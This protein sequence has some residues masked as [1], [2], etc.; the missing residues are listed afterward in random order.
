[1]TR[2]GTRS[3]LR[4]LFMPN[5]HQKRRDAIFLLERKLT[6]C[7]VWF[8]WLESHVRRLITASRH[9]MGP[10]QMTWESHDKAVVRMRFQPRG[11]SGKIRSTHSQF[12]RVD[13]NRKMPVWIRHYSMI[14]RGCWMIAHHSDMASAALER[15]MRC[16]SS[17]SA[18]AR[19]TQQQR[20]KWIV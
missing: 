12:T 16:K 13:E 1:M 6:N 9:S 17:L 20:A 7:K 19:P 10:I 8:E 5:S 3:I 18:G 11:S 14:I 4:F 15:Y 2:S